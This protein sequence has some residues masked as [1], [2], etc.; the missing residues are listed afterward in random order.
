M[1]GASWTTTQRPVRRTESR[2]AS[3]SSGFSV[4]RSSTSTEASPARAA[5]A[6]SHTPTIAPHAY[7]ASHTHLHAPKFAPVDEPTADLLTLV[8]DVDN[9]VGRDLPALFLAA[10]ERDAAAHDGLVSVNRVSAALPEDITSTERYSAMWSHYTGKGRPMVKADGWEI[11][12]GSRSGND[13]KPVKLSDLR[14]KKVVL[15]FYPKDD[16]PGCTK[17]A[18]SLRDEYG[19]FKKAGVV[20]YGIS[21]QDAESHKAFKAKYHLPFDL[22]MDEDGKI[23]DAFDIST[24][25]LIGYHH[26]QSVLIDPAGKIARFM[27]DVDPNTHTAEILKTVLGA[28]ALPS[29]RP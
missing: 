23:G 24:I 28:K 17:Q 12:E 29:P 15:Y 21:R 27:A 1:R 5:A 20:I 2:S 11:R 19:A 26:R 18:C 14:G 16:T 10:C 3:S 25:P 8:A 6:R 7:A 13:G 22:L 9:P 4:R